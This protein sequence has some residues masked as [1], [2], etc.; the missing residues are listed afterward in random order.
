MRRDVS[1]RIGLGEA[2][3]QLAVGVGRQHG[4]PNAHALDAG[5]LPEGRHAAAAGGAHEYGCLLQRDAQGLERQRG[6][7]RA[8]HRQQQRNAAEHLIALRG[9]VDG[10]EPRRG[11]R[12]HR[13]AADDAGEA[14]HEALRVISREGKARVRRR[15]LARATGLARNAE[16]DG[17]ARD[18]CREAVIVGGE[19]GG[20]RD[21]GR[22]LRHVPE[23]LGELAGREPVGLGEDQVERDGACAGRLQG[24]DDGGKLGARPGP[25]ADLGERGLVDV[26]DAHG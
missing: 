5:P 2:Q 10:A 24:V 19:R 26:D 12:Q 8:A 18:R 13:Q 20:F 1:A 11:A 3:P 16:S 9:P 25:L 14:R 6:I 7:E 23:Q 22:E 21:H 15:G 4:R 17:G